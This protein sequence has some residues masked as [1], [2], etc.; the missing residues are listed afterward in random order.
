MITLTEAQL[1]G[2]ITP[3]LWPFLRALALFTSLPV[4]GSRSV[5]IRVRI[6]LAGLIAFAAQATLPAVAPVGLDSTLALMLVAQQAV[7]GLSLGFAV[8]LVFAGVEFAG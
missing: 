7:I 8:Q 4:L 3:L 5:P 2:W 6:G 1:L